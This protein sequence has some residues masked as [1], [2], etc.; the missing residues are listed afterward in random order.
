MQSLC[1]SHYGSIIRR[2]LST[3][4]HLAKGDRALGQALGRSP[5]SYVTPHRPFSIPESV[6]TVAESL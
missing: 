3:H 4:S 5:L 6:V 1:S 2:S